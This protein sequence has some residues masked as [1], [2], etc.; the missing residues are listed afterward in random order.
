[1]DHLRSFHLK[2][3]YYALF[4]IP[5]PVKSV[6]GMATG[7]EAVKKPADEAVLEWNKQDNKRML[8]AVYRVGD[9]DR[10]IKYICFGIFYKQNSSN[11]ISRARVPSF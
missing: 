7:S 10:T 2:I 3:A 5:V 1:M 6:P 9:L 8:H 11:N 4:S